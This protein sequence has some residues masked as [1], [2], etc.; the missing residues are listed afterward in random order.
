MR[1][2]HD[3]SGAIVT[4]GASRATAPSRTSEVVAN[5]FT[6]TQSASTRTISPWRRP[7]ADSATQSP[8]AENGDSPRT[9]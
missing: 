5:G 7:S 8:S 9:R 4:G 2:F 3:T 1:P 6:V